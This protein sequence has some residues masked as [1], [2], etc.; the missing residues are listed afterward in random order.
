MWWSVPGDVLIVSCF[1]FILCYSFVCIFLVNVFLYDGGLIN[2][3]FLK[4]FAIKGASVF[5]SAV[6]KFVFSL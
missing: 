2:N 1:K 6:A 4:G 3:S 5:L